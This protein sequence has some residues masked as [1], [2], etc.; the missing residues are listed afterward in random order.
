MQRILGGRFSRPAR[1]AITD[2]YD[3]KRS[4]FLVQYPIWLVLLLGLG[5]VAA[6][7]ITGFLGYPP[8]GTI[9]YRLFADPYLLVGWFYLLLLILEYSIFRHPSLA[10]RRVVILTV[11]IISMGIVAWVYLFNIALIDELIHFRFNGGLLRGFFSNPITLTII[12][13]AIL[14]IFWFDTARRWVRRARGLQPNPRVNLGSYDEGKTPPELD[15]M[16]DIVSG[17]LIAGGVLAF[18][19][20]VIF[21]GYVINPLLPSNVCK[22]N[23][24][25]SCSALPLTTMNNVIALVSLIL[26]LV[27]LALTATLSGLGAVG[28][29]NTTQ[30]DRPHVAARTNLA[31]SAAIDGASSG[32]NVVERGDT[33]SRVAVSEEVSLTILSTLRNALDRRLR[34][35]FSL[36]C[37]RY[38]TFSGHCSR[39]SRR[40]A[41]RSPAPISRCTCTLTKRLATP[42]R[43][44]FPR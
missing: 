1:Q 19:L 11:F 20:G 37:S 26:G 9:E 6:F 12:N 24:F 7:A 36:C 28:G 43:S 2:L 27:I 14:G 44:C 15:P 13:L 17:D 40:A 29:V 3:E 34:L 33:S 41:S 35:I 32:T 16:T 25:G 5:G 22:V 8:T 39:C 4:A 23:L 18:V 42:T 31:P 38:A 21:S 30:L 10:W